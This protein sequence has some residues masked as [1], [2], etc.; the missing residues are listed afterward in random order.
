[1]AS[2][3]R[4]REANEL[5]SRLRVFHPFKLSNLGSI[6]IAS[7]DGRGPDNEPPQDFYSS[8]GVKPID[9]EIPPKFAPI[10]TRMLGRA[11]IKDVEVV[12]HAEGEAHILIGEAPEK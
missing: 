7:F 5:I 10:I 11:G 1:M 12:Y 9:A 8:I 2:A 6:S 4:V 3:E